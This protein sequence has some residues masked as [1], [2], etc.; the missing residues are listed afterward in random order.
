MI[1]DLLY[2]LASFELKDLLL[3]LSRGT[4]SSHNRASK[5]KPLDRAGAVPLKTCAPKILGGGGQQQYKD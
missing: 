4:T 5:L 3:L 1:K 2:F